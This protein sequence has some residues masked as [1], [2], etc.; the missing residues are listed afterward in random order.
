MVRQEGQVSHPFLE[1]TFCDPASSDLSGRGGA[2]LT[3]IEMDKLTEGWAPYR[4]L[5][6]YYTWAIADGAEA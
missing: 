2:Y 1:S 5:G 6:V 3:P 4:S